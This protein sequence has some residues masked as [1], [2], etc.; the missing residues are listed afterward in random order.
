MEK[1]TFLIHHE[2][3]LGDKGKIVEASSH[4]EAAMEYARYYNTH[5]DYA[6]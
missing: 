4:Y 2:D 6:L 5:C 1:T 3:Y